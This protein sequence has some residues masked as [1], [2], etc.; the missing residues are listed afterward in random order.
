[1]SLESNSFSKSPQPKKSKLS[2]KLNRFVK[3]AVLA[4]GVLAGE[5]M[6][7][8]ADAQSRPVTESVQQIPENVQWAASI[9]DAHVKDLPNVKTPGDALVWMQSLTTKLFLEASGSFSHDKNYPKNNPGKYIYN[10]DSSQ[11]SRDYTRKDVVAIDSVLRAA[12]KHMIDLAIKFGRDQ[13]VAM[14]S[15]RFADMLDSASYTVQLQADLA[16]KK[17]FPNK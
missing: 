2:G 4:G 6:V 17:N 13:S 11:F 10:A 9:L 14:M 1:M 16:Y 12:K 3:G 8:N 5:A 7:K 15:S